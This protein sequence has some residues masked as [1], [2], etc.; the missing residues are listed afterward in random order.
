MIIGG[1][2]AYMCCFTRDVLRC[3]LTGH[4]PVLIMEMPICLFYVNDNLYIVR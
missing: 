2:Y 3:E 1:Y 4:L